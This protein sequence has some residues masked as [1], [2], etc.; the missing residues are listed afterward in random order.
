MRHAA[1][2]LFDRFGQNGACHLA[3]RE[4]RMVEGKRVQDGIQ[5]RLERV[6]PSL[7]SPFISATQ[8]L[9]LYATIA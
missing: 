7:D 2:R 5:G 9:S 3:P 8:M 1:I 6:A 4:R